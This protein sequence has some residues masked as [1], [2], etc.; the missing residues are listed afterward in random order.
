LPDVENLLDTLAAIG[1]YVVRSFGSSDI[2]AARSRAATEWLE[3][4]TDEQRAVTTLLWLDSDTQLDP[5]G[6]LRLLAAAE[7][8]RGLVT[9]ASP[10]R[11]IAR[12]LPVPQDPRAEYTLGAWRAP[13]VPI[14]FAG[15]GCVA[16]PVQ[17]LRDMVKASLAPMTD[18]KWHAFFLPMLLTEDA[19]PDAPARYLAEDWAFWFRARHGLKTPCYLAPE[20][21]V[22][23]WGTH[24]YSWEDA[25]LPPRSVHSQITLQPIT[26]A[27]PPDTP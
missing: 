11:S 10:S 27:Q 8:T 17:L 13:L 4:S 22:I 6:C 7:E 3:G 18:H 21:R 5:A 24:P 12:L 1:V 9:A 2:C 19:E 25:L 14:L 23:H 20:H 26:L 16:H 15:F